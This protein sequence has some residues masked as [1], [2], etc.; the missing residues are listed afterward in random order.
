M[1]KN[2]Q[3]LYIYPVVSVL[4]VVIIF[5]ILSLWSNGD[6][7]NYK[8]IS[9]FKSKILSKDF[10]FKK[11]PPNEFLGLKLYDDFEKYLLVNKSE[12]RRDEMNNHKYYDIS[13]KYIKFTNPIPEYF[14]EFEF[15]ANE[16][17]KLVGI[18]A[19]FEEIRLKNNNNFLNICS[20]TRNVFLKQHNLS[21]LNFKNEYYSDGDDFFDFKSFDF[22]INN[23]K[24]RF[25]I[26]CLADINTSSIDY[27][28]F[29]FFYDINL[30]KDI[31][32]DVNLKIVPKKI[33]NN[34]IK[35]IRD[36]M[37]KQ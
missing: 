7:E 21:K 35:K 31:A 9:K 36:K 15:V 12:I 11:F 23:N 1:K 29:F 2:N 33:N 32:I 19:G 20:K 37:K 5:A 28:F 26:I 17:G 14:K 16:D 6:F 34:D 13:K 30:M 18:I 4:L 8:K 27:G 22:Q 3:N 25:S 24:T 10:K